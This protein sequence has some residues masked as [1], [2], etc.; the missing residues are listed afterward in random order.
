M[1]FLSFSRENERQADSLGGEYTSQV[2]YDG[3]QMAAFFESL[4]RMNPGS[5]R[6]GLPAWFSTHPNPEDRVKAVR[7]QA[8][9]WQRRLGDG[10]LSVNREEYLRRIEGM[11]YGEDPRQGY[12]ADGYFYHPELRFQFPVPAKWKVNH[13]TSERSNGQRWQ[14]MPCS[15]S[16]LT[17]ENSPAEAANLFVTK[18]KGRVVRAEAASGKRPSGAAGCFRSCHPAGES[19]AGFLFHPERKAG[20]MPFTGSPP[21]TR[22]PDTRVCSLTPWGDFKELTASR[23]NQRAAGPDPSPD[24]PDDA[25]AG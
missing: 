6:S 9:E 2:G 3:A 22:R 16:S 17:D 1:L 8:A 21:W 25:N 20:S 15:S 11:I 24:V 12:E 4:E 5:N 13:T 23:E 7:A 18:A 19:P 10:N 14:R